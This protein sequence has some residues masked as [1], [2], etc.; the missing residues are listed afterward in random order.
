MSAL[1]DRLRADPR[2]FAL[3][4]ALGSAGMLLG[5]L[6]FQ[7]LGDLA[8]CPMC[9]WQRWPHGI[10]ILIGLGAIASGGTGRGG[11][12]LL[13]LA[14]LTELIGAGIGVFHAGVERGLWRGPDTCTS[15]SIEGLS[16]DQLLAQIM[17]APLVRCDEIEW[18]LFG[19]SMAGW[20]AVI[21]FGLAACFAAALII[22]RRTGPHASSSASQ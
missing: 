3:I 17:D 14:A 11:Q 21:S 10:A 18:E 8:P 4:G 19:L 15:G 13:G 12:A 5:A 20:N 6:A 1:L 7:Y 9:I 22:G 2:A 16:P